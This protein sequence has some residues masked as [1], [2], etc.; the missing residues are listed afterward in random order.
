MRRRYRSEQR[1]ALVELVT[2][3]LATVSAAAARLGVTKSTAY[4]WMKQARAGT[5]RRGSAERLGR[6]RKTRAVIRPT[7]VRVVSTHDLA[8]TIAVRIG[9]AEIQVRRGF[10]GDLLREVVQALQ[11]GAG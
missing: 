6:P 4:H 7:F 2:A 1:S 5:P 8:T 3:G 10:D 9:G 11:G